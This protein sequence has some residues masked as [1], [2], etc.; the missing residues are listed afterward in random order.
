M[1][2]GWAP[3]WKGKDV[4]AQW[5]DLCS[6]G[7]NGPQGPTGFPGPKGPPVSNVFSLLGGDSGGSMQAPPGGPVGGCH[8]G[9]W[10]QRAAFQKRGPLSHLDQR[11]LLGGPSVSIL[12]PLGHVTTDLVT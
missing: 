5:A 7:P 10:L 12:G 2:G 8:L 1:G 4:C 9:S 3:T 11:G 6:Q